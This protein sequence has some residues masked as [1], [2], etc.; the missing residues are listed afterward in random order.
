M[1]PRKIEIEEDEE[2]MKTSRVEVGYTPACSDGKPCSRVE[3][4]GEAGHDGE[5]KQASVKDLLRD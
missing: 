3:E 2:M 5:E 4:S 1:N